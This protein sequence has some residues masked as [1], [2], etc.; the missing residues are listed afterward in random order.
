M[1]VL[2]LASVLRESAHRY[3]DAVALVDGSDRWTYAEVWRSSLQVAAGIRALGHEIGQPVALL[4]PNSLGFVAGYFGIL[5]AGGIVVPVP[6]MLRPAEIAHMLDVTRARLLIHDEELAEVATEAAAPSDVR[7]S[8]IPLRLPDPDARPV[9]EDM[10]PVQAEDTAV[11]FFTSG[12]TG[13][14]KG[15]RLTHLNLVLNATINAF[16]LNEFRRTDVTLGSLP[17]FHVFGQTVTMNAVFRAGARLVLQ[18]RFD[19]AE[20]LDLMVSEGATSF[21]GVPTMLI[22]LLEVARVRGDAP[23]LASITSGCASLPVAVIDELE[24][25]FATTVLEGYGLSE[26]SP[27][28]AVNQRVLGTRP[29][30]VGHPIWGVD[31]SIADADTEDAIHLLPR[32]SVGEV[33]V[34]GHNV[35]AGYAGDDAATRAAV[36]DGWFR[37][38]DL[39]VRDDAGFLTIV[40]RKKDLI[41]RGGYNVYPREVEEALAPLPGVLHVAVVGLPDPTLGEEVCAVIVP[42]DGVHLSEEAVL[43]WA[44]QRLGGQKYPR[45]VVFAD[46]LPLGPSQ[47]VHKRALKESL[48]ARQEQAGD[49]T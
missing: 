17:L 35:F 26:T 45:R 22:R 39:G 14:P 7:V 34:R 18:R 44:R 12:T 33:V 47:K 49:G 2:S 41:I 29:G 25:V 36:V 1:T 27:T 46:E 13:L 28:A 24:K 37:T 5:A 30:S 15:A 21:I 8:P 43:A 23:R 20:A 42:A 9:L 48:V 32:G 3:P 31:V 10:E 4:A 16:D 19:P 40:D 11:I 38:G 6:T